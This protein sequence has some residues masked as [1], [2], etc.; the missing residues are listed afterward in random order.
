MA[1]PATSKAI[2]QKFLKVVK[3]SLHYAATAILQVSKEKKEKKLA[4]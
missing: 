1:T 3:A 4:C 2:P